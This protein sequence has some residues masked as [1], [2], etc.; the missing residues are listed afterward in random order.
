MIGAALGALIIFANSVYFETGRTF[1]EWR[2]FIIDACPRLENI[3][4]RS[5][6]GFFEG[7]IGDT[8]SHIIVKSPVNNSF[9]DNQRIFS[10]FTIECAQCPEAIETGKYCVASLLRAQTVTRRVLSDNQ[11]API[12]GR[13]CFYSSILP[14]VGGTYGWFF[15]N[16]HEHNIE[17]QILPLFDGSAYYSRNRREP[18]SFGQFQ[19]VSGFDNSPY[20]D[21]HE[22]DGGDGTGY[23]GMGNV[24]FEKPH[25]FLAYCMFLLGVFFAIFA[26]VAHAAVCENLFRHSVVKWAI[27]LVSIVLCIVFLSTAFDRMIH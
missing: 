27:S 23:V 8:S 11:T 5:C 21:H 9:G 4:E 24:F 16:I 12:V 10:I 3:A 14:R 25:V 26:F 17:S 22:K 20:S 15:P 6:V 19:R 7:L 2:F 1:E 18:S 13:R